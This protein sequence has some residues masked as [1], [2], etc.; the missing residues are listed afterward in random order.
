[1]NAFLKAGNA[2]DEAEYQAIAD[3]FAAYPG[4]VVE[5]KAAVSALVTQV[6]STLSD[7]DA[8]LLYEVTGEEAPIAVN[9]YYPLYTTEAV[10]NAAGNGSSHSH[11]FNGTTYYM[12]NGVT[13]YHGNYGTNSY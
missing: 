6:A 2:R 10:A 8:A 13:F 12:P 4:K 3:A 1:M 11:T 5:R 7:E 9:G